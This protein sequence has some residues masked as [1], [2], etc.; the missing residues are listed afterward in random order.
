MGQNEPVTRARVLSLLAL[1]R[2]FDA[3]FER[4]R[5]LSDSALELARAG[6]DDRALGQVLRDRLYTIWAP[7][8]V[9]ERRANVA[10][11]LE[12][13]ERLDDPVLRHWARVSDMDVRSESGDLDGARK[14]LDLCQT[15]AE[16]VGHPTLKWSAATQAACLATL[17]GS[18]HEVGSS[19]QRVLALGTGGSQPDALR[20]AEV[21][22]FFQYWFEAARRTPWPWRRRTRH[23]ALHPRTGRRRNPWDTSIVGARRDRHRTPDN[24]MKQRRPIGRRERA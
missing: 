14:A 8:M 21:V 7:G 15:I 19:A 4:R 11:L 1:E 12:L 3:A 24:R 10:E 18:P 20:V 17:T 13:S 6:G 23:A 22:T 2:T 16:Q 9:E 5:A